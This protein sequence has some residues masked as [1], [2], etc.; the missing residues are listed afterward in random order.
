M[1]GEWSFCWRHLIRRRWQPLV[2]DPSQGGGP[3]GTAEPAAKPV[4]GPGRR[5]VV[6]LKTS[7]AT[8]GRK[9]TSPHFARLPTSPG[10]AQ[11]S[12]SGR[13]TNV[14]G[15]LRLAR[16]APRNPQTQDGIPSP[17]NGAS[18]RRMRSWL[19]HF[20][21]EQWTFSQATKGLLAPNYP[22]HLIDWN[23]Q[24]DHDAACMASAF[25]LSMT[26]QSSAEV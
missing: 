2:H 6:P 8:D 20:N 23:R 9:S 21:S 24:F 14:L 13:G 16:R 5:Y 26:M 18:S 1:W 7:T 17:S 10:P 11:R 19:S 25:S 22:F 4:V 12:V 3:C 15:C